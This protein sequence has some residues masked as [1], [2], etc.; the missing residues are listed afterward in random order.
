MAQEDLMK[1]KNKEAFGKMDTSVL[2]KLKAG[3]LKGM[4]K[5]ESIFDVKFPKIK[6]FKLK[7]SFTSCAYIGYIQPIITGMKLLPGQQADV[8]MNSLMVIMI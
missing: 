1:A 8:F 3:L 4:G 2:D 6:S 5:K 7:T